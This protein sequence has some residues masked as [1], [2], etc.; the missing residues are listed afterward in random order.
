MQRKGPDME[1]VTSG[2]GLAI[3]IMVGYF[4]PTIIAGRRQHHNWPAIFLL[5]LL[6]P[7]I[8][9]VGLFASSVLLYALFVFTAVISW[10]A[11]LI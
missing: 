6:G 8:L 3:A 11:A 9:V 1:T 4:I 5:N 10:P 2:G 7:A